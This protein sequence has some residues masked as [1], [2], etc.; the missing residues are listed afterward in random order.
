MKVVLNLLAARKKTRK[1]RQKLD[2]GRDNP[3]C[4]SM[5]KSP[6]QTPETASAVSQKASPTP[7]DEPAAYENL[8]E[9]RARRDY[10]SCPLPERCEEDMMLGNYS[11]DQF[12]GW[13]GG[14]GS[15]GEY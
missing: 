10:Y 15:A 4:I 13:D 6:L 12:G 7:H 3:Y 2:S 8:A 1:T 11:D 14:F 5:S 9:S